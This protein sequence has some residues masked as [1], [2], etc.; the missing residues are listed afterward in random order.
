LTLERIAVLA[1]TKMLS[2]MCTGGVSLASGT[3]VRPVKQFGTLLLGDLTYQ[4]R[5]VMQPFDIV[6]FSLIKPQ[7]RPPHSEDWTCDFVRARPRRVAVV[8]DRLAFM[9]R[10]SE[11]DSPAQVLRAERS[12]ALFEP[13]DVEAVFTMDDYSGKYE[14]RVRTPETGERPLPVTDIKWR[15]L[16]RSLL[17]GAGGT[18]K[19]SAS[20]L[21]DR[22]GAERVFVALGLG[23]LYE[24]RH[25]PLVIGVHAWPDYQARIDYRNL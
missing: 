2:G 15:A 6:E 10:H 17:G 25:W 19:M 18:L 21:R 1:V 14:A 22:L 16:G 11:P 5:T 13:S 12:L 24:G 20:E 23:R 3:W 7:P 9:R 4:D 8:E